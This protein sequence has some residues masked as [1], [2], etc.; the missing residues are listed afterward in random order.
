MNANQ[1]SEEFER[2]RN[3]ELRF[4]KE[5]KK[6]IC[7]FILLMMVVFFF[8]VYAVNSDGHYFISTIIALILVYVCSGQVKLDT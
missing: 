4:Q 5:K 7:A 1:Y 2:E 8:C 6:F 3:F